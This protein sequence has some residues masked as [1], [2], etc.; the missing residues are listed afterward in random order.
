[1]SIL[2][3]RLMKYEVW[4][5]SNETDFLFTKVFIF[6]KHQYQFQN[7]F[8]G[9]LHTNGDVVPTFSFFNRYGLQHVCYN[10]KKK[11]KKTS[12]LILLTVARF[13]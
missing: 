11:E 8:L 9:Q 13:L 1:M 6:F 5:K 12:V 4:Q 10:R 3:I 7:S 2:D